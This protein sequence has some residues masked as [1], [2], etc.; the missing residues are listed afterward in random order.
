MSG[1]VSGNT[2]TEAPPRDVPA[3]PLLISACLQGNQVARNDLVE[4]Y[5]RLVYSIPMRYG[6]TSDDADEIFRKVW[7]T[8]WRRLSQLH[9]HKLFSAW[10]IAITYHETYWAVCRK[11][12]S[13]EAIADFQESLGASASAQPQFEQ[14]E[15]NLSLVEA[16]R[17]LTP[18][19]YELVS[20]ILSE[21]PPSHAEL[22]TQRQMPGTGLHKFLKRTLARLSAGL[23]PSSSHPS[24]PGTH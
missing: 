9:E 5:R 21:A 1:Y 16:L 14:A 10:L 7:V 20:A 13:R 15:W 4:R 8:V 12:G 24:T 6:L 11:R 2:S 17:R 23:F 3:T 18:T 22:S 19:E